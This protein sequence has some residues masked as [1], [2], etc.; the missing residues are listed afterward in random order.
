MAVITIS[1]EY[2]SK[3]NV[4]ARLICD[5]LGYRYFDKE[6]MAQLGDQLGLEP[7]EIAGLP[8]D[9]RYHARSH[10]ERLFALMPTPSGDLAGWGLAAR[11]RVEAN[12]EHLSL[13]T[14]ES[15]I[16][17][18]HEHDTVVVVG[19]GGQFV[20]RDRPDVLHV[21]IVAPIEQRLRR[22]QES[23]GL[24]ADAARALVH[25]RDQAAADYVKNLYDVDVTDPM[26]YDLVVNTSNIP[27]QVAVELIVAALEGLPASR[28]PAQVEA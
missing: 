2:G 3:G 20:L 15:L 19:R 7:E 11:A 6:L 21:R 22:V 8:E 17:A 23:A 12:M 9:K 4:I 18:A 27:E 24:T 13:Q 16:H 1:R 14:V 25:R 26:L 10:I 5:R 28:R